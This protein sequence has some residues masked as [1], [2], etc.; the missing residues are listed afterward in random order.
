MSLLIKLYDPAVNKR[1]CHWHKIPEYFQS[2]RQIYDYTMD[3]LKAKSY[4]LQTGNIVANSIT[5]KGDDKKSK[6]L[7]LKLSN[8]KISGDVICKTGNCDL[9]MD[10]STKILGKIIGFNGFK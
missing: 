6:R 1:L 3:T 8:C 2:I 4:N 5:L 10:Q 9:I 7:Q